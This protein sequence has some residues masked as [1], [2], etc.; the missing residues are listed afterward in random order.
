MFQNRPHYWVAGPVIKGVQ[1]VSRIGG[2]RLGKKIEGGLNR[3]DKFDLGYD[4]I[5]GPIPI[6][7]KD[8]LKNLYGLL[9]NQVKLHQVQL[10]EW[11]GIIF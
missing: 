10:T 2:T 3:V 1:A 5:K 4:S 7:K 11:R 8:G 6:K 9:E